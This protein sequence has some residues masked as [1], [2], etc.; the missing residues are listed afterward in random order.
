[1]ENFA[2]LSVRSTQINNSTAATTLEDW[3]LRRS[4]S[5]SNNGTTTTTSPSR[6][7]ANTKVSN[8]NRRSMHHQSNGSL[9]SADSQSSTSPAASPLPRP[10]TVHSTAA[11][12]QM[13][14]GNTINNNVIPSSVMSQSSGG[15]GSPTG[16]AKRWNSTG[17]FVMTSPTNSSSSALLQNNRNT[18]KSLLNL[19]SKNSPNG[20]L[21]HGWVELQHRLIYLFM[22]ALNSLLQTHTHTRVHNWKPRWHIWCTFIVV[23]IH[24]R[25]PFFPLV[26]FTSTSNRYRKNILTCRH[27]TESERES[28]EVCCGVNNKAL[29][30][31]YSHSIIVARFYNWR[32]FKREKI[33]DLRLEVEGHFEKIIFK[34]FQWRLEF[35]IEIVSRF[36]VTNE[37]WFATI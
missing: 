3:R 27:I 19:Q 34:R 26:L 30:C 14:N 32:S 29:C 8:M 22:I 11:P 4:N 21:K 16:L 13:S 28:I 1:M 5:S 7:H 12:M 10:A 25:F 35:N 2:I 15:L 33:D 6:F 36:L 31:G 37:S 17:D 24:S 9:H 23:V 18:A 20:V